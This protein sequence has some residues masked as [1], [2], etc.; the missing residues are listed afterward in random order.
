MCTYSNCVIYCL[1]AEL[2]C[3]MQLLSDEANFGQFTMSSFDLSQYMTMDTAAL[4]ALNIMPNIF[5]GKFSLV[6]CFCLILLELCVRLWSSVGRIF[7][8][9]SNTLQ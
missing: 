8:L 3:F 5:D 1:S 2:Y 7:S 9:M 4:K 6:N